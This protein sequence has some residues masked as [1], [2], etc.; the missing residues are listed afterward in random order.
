M[1]KLFLLVLALLATT[2]LAREVTF[3]ISDEPTTF[4]QA[5]IGAFGKSLL[6]EQVE[7]KGSFMSW[8][9]GAVQTAVMLFV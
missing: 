9:M 5:V 3:Q 8:I 6:A 2:A 4:R 7:F 1:F